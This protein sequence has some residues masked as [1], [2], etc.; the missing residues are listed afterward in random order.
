MSAA[1][2]VRRKIRGIATLLVGASG[3]GLSRN[4]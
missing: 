2:E 1:R 4:T 3:G